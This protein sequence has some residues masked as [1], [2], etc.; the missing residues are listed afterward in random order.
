MAINC[1]HSLNLSFSYVGLS[2]RSVLLFG[3]KSKDT[4]SIRDGLDL[5]PFSPSQVGNIALRSPLEPHQHKIPTQY[6]VLS[7]ILTFKAKECLGKL[8]EIFLRFTDGI[9]TPLKSHPKGLSF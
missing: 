1:F 8:V 7:E 3:L 6:S 2:S 4:G 5:G 9:S